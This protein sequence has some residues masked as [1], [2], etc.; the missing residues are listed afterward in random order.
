MALGFGG[1]KS[2]SSSNPSTSSPSNEKPNPQFGKDGYY[3]DFSGDQATAENGGTQKRRKTMN[4]I[5]GPITKSITGEAA[6]E[7][8]STDA[9]VTIGKQMELEAGNAIKYRTCSWQKVRYSCSMSCLRAMSCL[10]GSIAI[11]A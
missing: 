8:D 1:K 10:L 9:S 4:R 3:G 7:D 2:E 5:D 11:A 6:L